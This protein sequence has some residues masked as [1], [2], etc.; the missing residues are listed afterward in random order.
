MME[1]NLRREAIL[2]NETIL[3]ETV[4]QSVECDALMPDYCPDIR[5]ILKCTLTPTPMNHSITAGRLEVEGL[6][7]LNILYISAGGEPARGEYKVPFSRMLEL[8]GEAENAVITV[9]MQPGSV[10]C[11][12]V[13]QRRLEVRGSVIIAATVT[14]CREEMLLCG[15]DEA[16]V[17]LRTC[18][19]KGVRLY[20]AAEREQRLSQTTVLDGSGAPLTRVLRCDAWVTRREEK[21]TAG[22]LTV[23]GEVQAAAFCLN[24]TGG[25]EWVEC[26]L[27]YELPLELPNWGEEHTAEV[28]CSVIAASAEPCVDD[29]GEYRSL[30]WS[31]TVCA[32][33]RGYEPYT[34]SVCTDGY[35]TRYQ[36][37]CRTRTVQTAELVSLC[38]E[39]QTL[40]ESLPLPEETEEVIALWV[41]PEGCTVRSDGDGLSAEGRLAL[42]M[43]TRMSDGELYSF[44][45]VL[46]LQRHIPAG[47]NTRWDAALEC[48]SFAWE[49]AGE[50]LLLTCELQWQG[51]LW[52]PVREVLLEDITVDENSPKTDTRPRGLYIYMA[53][54]GESL[55]EIAKR[56]NTSEARIREDNGALGAECPAGAILIP[57]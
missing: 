32:A 38:R 36:S 55:W 51:A 43:L 28:R 25:W 17:Q 44:D 54:E 16:A 37:A 42:T 48:R 56:Y 3:E 22:R 13:N 6:A 50:E 4:E 24:E 39:A 23:F 2:V 52:R 34:A 31:V 46:E 11:R 35:S 8:H 49:A 14:A 7:N 30:D 5:R 19:K 40:R 15:S 47:E 26:T 20:A 12:A 41:R 27:P 21:I 9:T 18:E 29:D 45:R 33:A 10:T 57:V 1:L 53:E